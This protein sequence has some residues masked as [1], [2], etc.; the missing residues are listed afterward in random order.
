MG[1]MPRL[2]IKDEIRYRKGS[3]H[4]SSNCKACKYFKAQSIT[5]SYSSGD[6]HIEDRCTIVGMAS[7]AR[8]RVRPDHTCD[9][10]E[11]SESYNQYLEWLR[12]IR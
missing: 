10:Q 3:T 11:M 7:S 4:E 5:I 9:R 1:S 2:K 12:G 8:Y 6:H